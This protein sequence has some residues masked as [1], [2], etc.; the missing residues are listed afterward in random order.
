MCRMYYNRKRY[1]FE[2]F[3]TVFDEL[4]STIEISTFRLTSRSVEVTTFLNQIEAALGLAN[5]RWKT[6]SNI[7][8]TAPRMPRMQHLVFRLDSTSTRTEAT[9]QEVRA[10]KVPLPAIHIQ[11]TRY[12]ILLL[13]YYRLQWPTMNLRLSQLNSVACYDTH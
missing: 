6:Y 7:S 5:L 11:L 8:E 13:I 12:V 3:M 9:P 1:T 4:T 2:C 10:T